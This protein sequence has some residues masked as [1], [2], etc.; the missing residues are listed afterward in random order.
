MEQERLDVFSSLATGITVAYMT[1]RHPTRQKIHLLLIEDLGHKAVS[2]DSMKF[3]FSINSHDTAALLTSMLESMQALV[4]K[5]C[6]I[7][8]ATYSKDTALMMQL[9]VPV[10]IAITHFVRFIIDPRPSRGYLFI[11]L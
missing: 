3:T 6:S 7:F 4:R 9:I 1:D 8:Y 5:S 10:L 11:H 2:L